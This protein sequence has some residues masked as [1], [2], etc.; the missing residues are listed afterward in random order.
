MKTLEDY[1]KSNRIRN[2]IIETLMGQSPKIPMM[3]TD[4]LFY[5]AF[6]PDDKSIDHKLHEL[7]RSFDKNYRPEETHEEVLNHFCQV[8]YIKHWVSYDVDRLHYFQRDFSKLPSAQE[9]FRI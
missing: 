9:A 7:I 4:E 8:N 5:T 2:S 1:Q 3:M 6:P